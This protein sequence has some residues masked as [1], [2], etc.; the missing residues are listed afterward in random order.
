MNVS[1]GFRV[2]R[3]EGNGGKGLRACW[4]LMSSS[5]W[6]SLHSLV[7]CTRLVGRDSRCLWCG[8]SVGVIQHRVLPMCSAHARAPHSPAEVSARAC[9][10]DTCS[11]LHL[12]HRHLRCSHACSAG[13]ARM[14]QSLPT[15]VFLAVL[16]VATLH[17]RRS[18][19]CCVS[20]LI[21]AAS[22]N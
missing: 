7:G 16:W 22:C 14:L 20:M 17:V 11:L 19:P 2:T 4:I 3:R 21:P 8:V 12:H 18:S 6:R 15:S 5:V 10:H 1:V 9:S 13:S